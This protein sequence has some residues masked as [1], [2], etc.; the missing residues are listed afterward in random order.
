[1]LASARGVEA[2]DGE[3]EALHRCLLGR[4][5]TARTHAAAQP[6]VHALD[7]IGIPYE[8]G[9]MLPVTHDRLA[10]RALASGLAAASANCDG[11]ALT[12]ATCRC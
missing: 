2:A 1:M 11:S 7:R 3:V 12:T 6:G 5:V 10:R 9:R 4:E 8:R